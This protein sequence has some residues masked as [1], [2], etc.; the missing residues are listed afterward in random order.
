MSKI[1]K[2]KNQ[3]NLDRYSITK[4][5]L[6][7]VRAKQFSQ[8]S[9]LENNNFISKASGK[10]VPLM[11]ISYN[12]NFSSRYY[13][14]I[15][16]K[17]DTFT[18]VSL[19]Q[20]LTPVFLTITLDG[21]FRRF[22]KNNYSE[23]PKY[24]EQYKVHISNNSKNGFYWDKIENEY[25]KWLKGESKPLD[26]KDLYKIL[27]NQWN[28]FNRSGFI[29]RYKKKGYKI[30][31]IRVVEPHKDGTPHFHILLYINKNHIGDL[32]E[33]FEK[34]FPAPRNHKSK[35]GYGET[36]GFQTNI[37]SAAG[38]IL[39][40]ILKSFSDLKKQKKVD[41]L[42][43]WYIIYKIPRII[44]S[45][46]L[47]SQ[48]DYQAVSLVDQRWDY[49]TDIKDNYVFNKLKMKNYYYLKMVD[50]YGRVIVYDN[51]LLQL[52][53]KGIL[54]KEIG[55]KYIKSN[56]W[57]SYKWSNN[58]EL[59]HSVKQ[60]KFIKISIN[61]LEL[62]TKFH[63]NLYNRIDTINSINRSIEIEYDSNFFTVKE[64]FSD[65]VF[66]S[67]SRLFLLGDDN[68]AETTYELVCDI[69]EDRK[70]F[71]N[72]KDSCKIIKD[73]DSYDEHLKVSLYIDI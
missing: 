22:L 65:C 39:K 25:H 4:S 2:F 38:Y 46:T 45:H 59:Y 30:N 19:K 26:V 35:N 61:D 70:T 31:Y 27:V 13:S 62:N 60:L 43:A 24:R 18:R 49:L 11:T 64:S 12:P 37:R 14:R 63:K 47:L 66:L 54:I 7:M 72:F 15:L 51:G 42:Q 55:F 9:F 50:N 58:K 6:K 56:K 57:N 1:E 34:F 16:N 23:W 48:D 73:V 5:M 21:F 68:I 33:V 17:V 32:K 71:E 36:Y 10:S 8:K 41:R 28:N 40:Y 69:S 52:F 53:N 3:I 44:T 67:T 29:Q 20:D